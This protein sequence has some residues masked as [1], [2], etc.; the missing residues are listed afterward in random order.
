[1]KKF[2]FMGFVGLSMAFAENIDFITKCYCD[3]NCQKILNKCEAKDGKSCY[4]LGVSFGEYYTLPEKTTI[5]AKTIIAYNKEL[6]C[7]IEAEISLYEKACELQESKACFK[8][9]K[10]NN[11][12]G[13]EFSRKYSPNISLYEKELN[14]P[15]IEIYKKIA[16]DFYKGA[17]SFYQKACDLKNAEAC[18]E[19]SSI[20]HK[21]YEGEYKDIVVKNLIKADEYFNL[22]V[23][24]DE[25]NQLFIKDCAENN[26]TACHSLAN[27]YSYSNGGWRSVSEQKG[28]AVEF[29][30]KACN[31]KDNRSCGELVSI[32][33]DAGDLTRAYEF[34]DKEMEYYQPE[35]SKKC[36]ANDGEGCYLWGKNYDSFY[37]PFEK[38]DKRNLSKRNE[39]YQK[40]CDLKY[41]KACIKLG[42]I[43]EKGDE[44]DIKQAVKFYEKA[45]EIND[46]QGCVNAGILHKKGEGITQNF[47][48]AANLY[49]KACELEHS[50]G[51]NNLAILYENGEGVGKNTNNAKKFYNKACRMGSS[52]ACVNLRQLRIKEDF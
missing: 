10:F 36:K 24:Y 49:K 39:L 29:Y 8:L 14:K 44:K 12:F 48:K 21:D 41:G 26:P 52:K 11:E 13:F 2:V 19:L 28:K 17:V 37:N 45:C 15:Y 9:G 32:Y 1:M 22:Y 34:Y 43:Y 51:C 40:A 25:K 7:R 31:L 5:V 50:A 4:D 18:N 27:A 47:S 42:S 3:E 16:T 23:E 35:N 6:D 38:D 33:K 20:Y 46:S 30:E